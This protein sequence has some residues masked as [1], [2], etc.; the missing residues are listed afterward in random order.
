MVRTG[1]RVGHLDSRISAEKTY[2]PPARQPLPRKIVDDSKRER[3]A[4]A[5]AELVHEHGPHGLGTARIAGQ[6]RIA[7]NTIYKLFGGVDGGLRFACALGDE[8][9]AGAV[10][11]AADEQDIWELRVDAAIGAL[12]AAAREEPLLAELSLMHRASILGAPGAPEE[13]PVAS[14]LIAVLRE[15]RPP[16]HEMRGNASDVIDELI[17]GGI[18]TIVGTRLRKG[19]A[20]SLTRLKKGLVALA[21][22]SG[23]EGET[24]E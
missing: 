24:V 14:A 6:A 9:L 23:F 21:L 20:G 19:R 12:L 13:E 8:R 2:W 5:I 10:A 17:A 4:L 11:A 7:R 3:C 16:Q 22:G 15:G 1:V 18:L